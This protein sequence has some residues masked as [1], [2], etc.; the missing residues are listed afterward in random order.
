MEPQDKKTSNKSTALHDLHVKAKARMVPF[1]GWSMPVSYEGT[2][3]EHRTVREQCG[4]F[5]VSHMGEIEVKGPE[6]TAF[7]QHMTI[8]DIAKLKDGQGQ[9]TAM[10]KPDGGMIDDLI[11]YRITDSAYFLCVNAS[12]SEKDFAW[13]VDNRGKFNVTITNE[14]NQWSQLAIQGPNSKAALGHLLG[15]ADRA[16]FD[17]QEYM[18]MSAV[19]LFGRACWI[20]RTGYTGEHGYELYMPNEI[21]VN[22]WVA[23]L[24]TTHTTGI[25][26]IGLAA[27]DTLRLE[28][29]YLLYGNDM[30]D[31]VS[32]LEAGIGWA[33][34]LTKEGFIGKS[35]LLTQKENGLKRKI[36]AFRMT[37]D[38]IPRQGMPCLSTDGR[39]IGKV[40]S[41]SV[42][43]TV[44]GAGGMAL[45]D[46][47][48]R[49]GEEFLV[50]VRG[51]TKS[52]KIA[53]RPLYSAKVK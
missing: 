29:C 33:V 38:G 37:G 42:L 47:G 4:L 45:I 9:Y 43:P 25:K 16:R 48:F 26:P 49:E 19:R 44:G 30:D 5:D 41:G 24:E 50:D 46:A 53:K 35:A 10:L 36:Q 6:A 13:L 27:R 3:A 18:T 11:I 39:V 14:S 17:R 32:P 34:K 8:N 23:L 15:P 40:T 1:G 51:K 7:L 31:T 21:A 52:A 2:L 28:A 12:N 22:C 20:A